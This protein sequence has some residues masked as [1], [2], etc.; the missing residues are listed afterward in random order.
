MARG[1]LEHRWRIR[2]EQGRL[3]EDEILEVAPLA[4]QLHV[5][6]GRAGEVVVLQPDTDEGMAGREHQHGVQPSL[7]ETGGV[8][9]REIEAGA[10]L[11]LQH[12][13]RAADFLASSLEARG[14]QDVGDPPICNRRPDRLGQLPGA[15][16]LGGLVAVQPCFAPSL[17]ELGRGI[18]QDDVDGGVVGA[19]EGGEEFGRASA[20]TPVR[21]RQN[22]KLFE[23][24]AFLAGRIL[25]DDRQFKTACLGEVGEQS[26]IEPNVRQ[27][28]VVV[29]SCRNAID[30]ESERLDDGGPAFDPHADIGK[31]LL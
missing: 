9:Q 14:R 21:G 22:P 11:A 24:P 4:E 28:D 6:D 16:L 10:D 31:L 3:D 17:A 18:A 2:R 15:G 1:D 5:V 19:D 12:V 27:F 20:T 26:R 7:L 8:E 25:D 13:A 23:M 30:A 29:R